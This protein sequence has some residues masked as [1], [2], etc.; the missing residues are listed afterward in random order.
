MCITSVFCVFLVIFL[1]VLFSFYVM[2]AICNHFQLF[3]E[4]T[5]TAAAAAVP[6]VIT[7]VVVV[8][9]VVPVLVLMLFSLLLLM[10]Q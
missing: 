8:A 7:V 1:N 4:A 9:E 10:L 3:T 5:A 6:A 2:L